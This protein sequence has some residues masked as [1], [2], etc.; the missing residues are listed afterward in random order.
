[1]PNDNIYIYHIYFPTSGKS[2]IGQTNDLS[3]RLKAHLKAGSVVCK[4]LYKYDDWI[5]SVL[6]TCQSRDVANTLEI[7]EIRNFNSIAPNGYNLTAGG[8]GTSC[9]K[10]TEEW[11]IERSIALQG[12]QRGK[13]KN[14]GNKNGTGY[15]HTAE[16]IEKI[17]EALTGRICSKE[18][19]DKIRRG[20][21]GLKSPE[22][23]KRNKENNPMKNP[24]VV[25]KWKLSRLK[26]SI[27]KLEQNLKRN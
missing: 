26:T 11:K 2:Y 13:G 10:H 7:E 17:T 20:N 25:L 16:A 14:L 21:L 23:T 3:V 5:T 22:T 12:N 9:Y 19:Q 6:H 15:K 4:A 18:T 1:M 27:K 24:D 8:D